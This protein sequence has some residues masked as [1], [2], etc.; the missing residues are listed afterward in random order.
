MLRP[1]ISSA[2]DHPV[3]VNAGFPKYAATSGRGVEA[4]AVSAIL[5]S[6][7]TVTRVGV[8]P[9]SQSAA[10]PL[11]IILPLGRTTDDPAASATRS[12][13]PIGEVLFTV[14]VAD[15]VLPLNDAETVTLVAM[16]TVMADIPKGTLAAPG[17]TCTTL[18]T[19]RTEG[20]LLDS[21]TVT[22]GAEGAK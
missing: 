9:S 21:V 19:R 5:P 17:D 4:V 13:H 3:F 20:L 10:Q 12:T 7:E 6:N 15:F 18:S 16:G 22:G 14:R 1:L 2:A 11:A 8:L